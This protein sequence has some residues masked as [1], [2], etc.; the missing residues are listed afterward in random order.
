MASRLL[1]LIAFTPAQ[2]L[3][4]SQRLA[5]RLCIT[6]VMLLSASSCADPITPHPIASVGA[7]QAGDCV[8]WTEG[9][10][11]IILT[12]PALTYAEYTTDGYVYFDNAQSTESTE[13][14]GSTEPLIWPSGFFFTGSWKGKR[15]EGD[16]LRD[17][18]SSSYLAYWTTLDGRCDGWAIIDLSVTEAIRL[19]TRHATNL[20]SVYFFDTHCD[21]EV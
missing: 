21:P 16:A 10:D 1:D 17:G 11:P 5:R 7:R 18:W 8:E 12:D 14:S 9:C 13:S 19:G 15:F 20:S 6:L 3:M 2:D 4:H